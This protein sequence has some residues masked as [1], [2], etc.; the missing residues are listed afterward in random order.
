[1]QGNSTGIGIHTR[2]GTGGGGGYGHHHKGSTSS[3]GS[4]SR[5]AEVSSWGVVVLVLRWCNRSLKRQWRRRAR[6]RRSKGGG[7]LLIKLG[8]VGL[9]SMRSSWGKRTELDLVLPLSCRD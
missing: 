1:M 3:G 9:A 4:I 8:G 6:K 2:I 7:C 5:T